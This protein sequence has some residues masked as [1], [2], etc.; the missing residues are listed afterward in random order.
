M[1]SKEKLNQAIQNVQ[2]FCPNFKVILKKDSLLHR[3]IG[4]ILALIGNKAYMSDF[5]TTIGQTCALPSSCNTTIPDDMWESITHEGL[6]AQDSAYMS[7][8]LFGVLYLLPQLLGIV[9]LLYGVGAGI[10]VLCGAPLELLWGLLGLAC[11][12]PLPALGRT[13]LEVRAYTV[14]MAV[15][16][17]TN[18]ITD[19]YVDWLVG[20][21]TGPDYYYMFWPFKGVIKNYFNGLLTQLKTGNFI[22]TPYLLSCKNLAADLNQ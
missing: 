21:F 4:K 11:L 2:N 12:A 19:G 15:S 20:I 14:T 18:D 1:T 7:N 10:A 6:H 3:T 13:Y 5:I 8:W 17:W 22:L 9:A 16:Y